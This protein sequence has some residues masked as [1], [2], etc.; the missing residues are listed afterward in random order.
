MSRWSWLWFLTSTLALLLAAQVVFTFNNF[1][2]WKLALLATEYGHR[3][4]VV[5][6]LLAIFHWLSGD[7]AM[8]ILAWCNVI[9]ALVLF[10]PLVQA[11]SLSRSLPIDLK[12]ALGGTEPGDETP[13][14]T[15]GLWLGTWRG[16][17]QPEKMEYAHDEDGG[18]ALLLF[19]AQSE[20]PS[21]CVVVIHAGS[22]ENERENEFPDWSTHWA[23]RGYAV[24]AMQY[25]LAPKHPWPAQR[26]DVRLALAFLK[27]NAARLG[28]DGS[29][30]ILLGRSAGG[31]ISLAS[32][33]ELGDP[34]VRG[35]V[36]LYGPADLV[37]SMAIGSHDDVL[38]SV[39]LIENYI[40]GGLPK[41]AAGYINA[42]P[43][44]TASAGCCPTLL[45]HGS[46]DI[47]VWNL[48]S[49]RMAARLEAL[50]VPHYLLELPLGVHGFDWAYDGAGGQLARYALDQFF[51]TVCKMPVK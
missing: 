39:R 20:K 40:G 6:L 13:L 46:R 21:P 27:A 12:A 29:R 34:S 15:K 24:A 36:S 17:Q 16:N 2:N 7:R 9:A 51:D 38:D 25:R 48:Q 5:A 1:T 14:E 47:L 22:W 41:A 33:Y 31:Q 35:C 19:R 45:L 4:A 18:R 43:Y 37:F 30:F 32:A 50:G 8:R 23:S 49:R 42:S 26:E 11:W 10:V 3:M 44:L 28:V